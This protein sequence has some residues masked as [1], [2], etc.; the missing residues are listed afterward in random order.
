[1]ATGNT[2]KIINPWDWDVRVRERNLRK[3]L[4]DDKEVEKH[5]SQLPDVIEE[6]ESLTHWQPALGGRED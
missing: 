1:M 3:G 6:S 5:L 4:I 2:T